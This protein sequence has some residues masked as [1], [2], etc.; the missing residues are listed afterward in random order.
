MTTFIIVAA[1][2]VAAAL[3]WLLLPLVRAKPAEGPS[4][5][6]SSSRTILAIG[7]A[8]LV[9]ALAAVMYTTL[10]NWDW[11]T[12][13]AETAQAE[14]LQDLLKQLEARLEKNPDD[15]NGW[16]LLGRSYASMQRY[17]QAISAYQRAYDLTRGENV[18]AV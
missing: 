3:L 12:V 8:L 15:A 5:S 9:P 14:Q 4:E 6:S 2:M 16:M 18:D 1:A 7:I 13:A 17:Q 11:K 10:S